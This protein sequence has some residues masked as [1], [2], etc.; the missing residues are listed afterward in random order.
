MHFSCVKRL[1]M[2]KV[3]N[4][5]VRLQL[6]HTLSVPSQNVGIFVL[7]YLPSIYAYIW[8][9]LKLQSILYLSLE[10]ATSIYKNTSLNWKFK[11]KKLM[12]YWHANYFAPKIRQCWR[13]IGKSKILTFIRSISQRENNFFSWIR[14]RHDVRI[15]S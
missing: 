3:K 6:N 7:F 1:K 15:F 8:L 10:S 12:C 9:L 14:Q 11:I 2:S 13:C 4:L 5:V